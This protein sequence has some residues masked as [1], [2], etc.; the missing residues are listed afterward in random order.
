[1]GSITAI[2]P[3]RHIAAGSGGTTRASVTQGT[4]VGES[5]AQCAIYVEVAEAVPIVSP[6]LSLQAREFALKELPSGSIERKGSRWMMK[7]E[8]FQLL[9]ISSPS[10]CLILQRFSDSNLGIVRSLGTIRELGPACTAPA[11]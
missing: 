6:S 1:M 11:A 4:T 7:I 2:R 8:E 10:A 3:G 5:R 9:P